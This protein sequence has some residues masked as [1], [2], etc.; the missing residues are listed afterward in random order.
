ME[1]VEVARH[2]LE[3]SDETLQRIAAACGFNTIDTLA[4]AFRRQLD[5]TPNEYRRRFRIG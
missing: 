4:R 3:T 1:W 5:T 2:R